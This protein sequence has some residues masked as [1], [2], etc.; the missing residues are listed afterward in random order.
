MLKRQDYYELYLTWQRMNLFFIF[1]ILVKFSKFNSS[2]KKKE[3]SDA[4]CVLWEYFQRL[5]TPESITLSHLVSLFKYFFTSK[6]ICLSGYMR[7]KSH[8]KWIV[9][10]ECVQLFHNWSVYRMKLLQ[11][12]WVH[13]QWIVLGYF[14]QR[15][16]YIRNMFIRIVTWR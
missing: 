2:W 9:L 10:V 15:F 3:Q 14:I 8:D 5:S 4:Y 1:S 16:S 11:K 6:Y 7:K 12:K 13:D